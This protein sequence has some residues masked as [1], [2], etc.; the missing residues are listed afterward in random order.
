VHSISVGETLLALRLIRHMRELRPELRVVLSTTTTTGFALA[1]EN[2]AEWLVALYNPV[3]AWP[4]ARRALE[5]VRPE[6]LIFIEAVWPNLLAEAVGRGIPA[7]LIARLSPRSEGRFRRFRFFTGPIFRLLDVVS[8]QEPEDVGRWESLGVEPERIHLTGNIKFD[9]PGRR[10][11]RGGK[12]RNLLERLCVPADAPVLLGGSTFQGE[13]GMLARICLRLR[14]TFPGLFLIIV[15]R[16]VERASEAAAEVTEAGMDFALRSA[17]AEREQPPD[18]LLVNT[19]GELRAWYEV[20]TVVFIGKS[21]S[22]A[23]TGGQNP[24]EPIF[25]EKPV[26]F[27]PGME[28]FR[29][30]VSRLVEGEAALEVPDEAALERAIAELLREPE[31]REAMARRALEMVSAHQGATERTARL[32]LG[33]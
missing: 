25:A 8:V 26:L 30:V 31:R 9:Q 15:P 1:E 27:G 3:D 10:D 32:V 5:T 21:L 7:S 23:A 6:R 4:L 19:T 33:L 13:E 11:E 18:C 16:H 20:A 2:A 12:F 28:N 22:P 29:A 24:V 17:A 14:R